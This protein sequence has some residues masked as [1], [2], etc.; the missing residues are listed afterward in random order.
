[1]SWIALTDWVRA[2]L[3]L[4]RVGDSITGPVNLVAPEP[5]TN[6]IFGKTLAAV[7]HRPALVPLPSL[8]VELLF[9]EMG[10]ATLLAGQRVRPRRL[11]E[12]GFAF[13]EPSLEGALR[14]ELASSRP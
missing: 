13:T 7:L 4:L 10:G 11:L 9:G 1:M 2:T 8:A 14:H 12:A 3:F 5:V 6:E